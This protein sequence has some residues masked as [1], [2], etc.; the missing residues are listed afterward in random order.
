MRI[1]SVFIRSSLHLCT[2]WYS[3]PSQQLCVHNKWTCICL[4]ACRSSYHFL[5]VF[6]WHVVHREPSQTQR[7][8]SRLWQFWRNFNNHSLMKHR[9]V[10]GSGWPLIRQVRGRTRGNANVEGRSSSSR[11]G[12][13]GMNRKNRG[14]C[15][16]V[17]PINRR[18]RFVHG[19]LPFFLSPNGK[20][21]YNWLNWK[22]FIETCC[23]NALLSPR[24][25][26]LSAASSAVQFE[27]SLG[28]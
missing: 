4:S 8:P 18:T 10:S 20:G 17:A 11:C 7:I 15:K 26:C 22:C 25:A 6:G 13:P 28:L 5:S 9:S 12:A 1:R 19:P 27:Y 16:W 23:I 14:I 3:P 2:Y 24:W 21:C